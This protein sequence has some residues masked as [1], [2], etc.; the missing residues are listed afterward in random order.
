M[1]TVIVL[2][3]SIIGTPVGVHPVRLWCPYSSRRARATVFEK[4]IMTGQSMLSSTFARRSSTPPLSEPSF[5][6]PRC[7]PF[8][9][10]HTLPI[11]PPWFHNGVIMHS[12]SV[13]VFVLLYQ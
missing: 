2:P 5:L 8:Q 1:K 6:C 9:E 7:T 11:L 13:S 10:A 12:A 4:V 3:Q